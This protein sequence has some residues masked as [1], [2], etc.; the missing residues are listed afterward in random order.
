MFRSFVRVDNF[1]EGASGESLR[2]IVNPY[3][4]VSDSE[5]LESKGKKKQ[6]V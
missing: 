3:C 6:P 1:S 2:R 4:K 5:G